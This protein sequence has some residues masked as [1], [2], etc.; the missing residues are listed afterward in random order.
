MVKKKITHCSPLKHLNRTTHAPMVAIDMFTW[1]L[2]VANGICFR[3]YL[4][5][6]I[7]YD[8]LSESYKNSANYH[9]LGSLINVKVNIT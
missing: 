5:V 3:I 2:I 4:R 9:L 1:L 8:F 7:V 6:V